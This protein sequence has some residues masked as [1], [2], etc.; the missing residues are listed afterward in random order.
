M[1]NV[2]TQSAV[3]LLANY[4]DGDL[5]NILTGLDIYKTDLKTWSDLQKYISDKSSGKI[6]AKNL[7]DLAAPILT[8][9]DLIVSKNIPA[10]TI[11]SHVPA[12]KGNMLW[13]MWI[14][15]GAA[16]IFFFILFWRRRK[17]EKK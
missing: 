5:K 1:D 12:H 15:I 13:I 3:D 14:V 7:D 16:I 10:D 2:L 17:K 6:T 9:A 11:K 4:S 8:E